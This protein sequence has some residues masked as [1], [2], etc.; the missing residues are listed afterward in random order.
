MTEGFF[1]GSLSSILASAGDEQ[2]IAVRILVA[3]SIGLARVA[4][5]EMQC[6]GGADDAADGEGQKQVFRKKIKHH[7]QSSL[8]NG[9]AHHA[10]A[11]YA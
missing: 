2:F 7:S 8:M 1:S 3:R 6:D 10:P 9:K 5:G 11:G 4:R